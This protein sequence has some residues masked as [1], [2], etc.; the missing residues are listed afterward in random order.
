ME[1]S[2]LPGPLPFHLYREYHVLAIL[3]KYTLP[4]PGMHL[5]PSSTSGADLV[6]Y[7][8]LASRPNSLAVSFVQVPPCSQALH[9]MRERQELP[10]CSPSSSSRGAVVSTSSSAEVKALCKL[11]HVM[12]REGLDIMT[13]FLFPGDPVRNQGGRGEKQESV[14]GFSLDVSASLRL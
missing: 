6:F 9:C 14:L 12:C 3:R 1:G 7:S 10:T 4:Y 5:A 8:H 2:P 13:F 11:E